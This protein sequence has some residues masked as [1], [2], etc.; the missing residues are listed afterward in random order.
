MFPLSATY[1]LFLFVSISLGNQ[2]SDFHIARSFNHVIIPNRDAWAHTAACVKPTGRK[3]SREWHVDKLHQHGFDP[4]D[5]DPLHTYIKAY[6]YQI[7]NP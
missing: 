2:L 6:N 7:K 1:A 5:K 3:A 4:S